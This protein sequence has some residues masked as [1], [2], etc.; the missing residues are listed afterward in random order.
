[1]KPS[2]HP[3]SN[4]EAIEKFRRAGVIAGNARK[5]AAS[6]VKPG[7]SLADVMNEVEDYIRSEGAG[8]AFPAQTSRNQVAAHYCPRPG[9]TMVYAAEDVVKVDI[10]VEVDGFV[11]DNAQ[12]VYLGEKEHY[13]NMI[14]ASADG[15]AAAI[16]VAGPGVEVRTIS[17]A[18]LKAIEARGFRPVY[19]LT[20]HGVARW[21]VHCAPQIPAAPDK[22]SR[23][24]LE[25]GM[26]IAIEPFAT[27]G[28]GTVHESGRAEIFMMQKKPRKMKG[29]DEHVWKVIEGMNGLPFARRTFVGIPADVIEGTLSRLQRTGCLMDFPPLVDPDPAARIAQ[30]EHTMIVTANGVEVT[31]G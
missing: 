11:A 31:T 24:V 25:E 3:A 1:M 2:H 14:Q 16:A 18:I 17:T 29:I 27:D 4:P 13:Q 8:M 12:T 28:S 22:W 9:D 15:L 26:V 21:T 20:G 7:A 10:G 5:L 19:N 6:L 23:G 30:T